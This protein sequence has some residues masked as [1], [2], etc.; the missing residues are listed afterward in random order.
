M[1]LDEDEVRRL[2]TGGDA[3]LRESHDLLAA[4]GIVVP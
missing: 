4:I 3:G 1:I 2:T